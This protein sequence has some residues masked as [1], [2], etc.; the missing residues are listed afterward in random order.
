MSVMLLEKVPYK[1]GGQ[2]TKFI[3]KGIAPSA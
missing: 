1:K 2:N 3:K